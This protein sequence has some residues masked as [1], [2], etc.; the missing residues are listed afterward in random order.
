MENA[1]VPERPLLLLDTGWNVLLSIGLLTAFVSLLQ[2]LPCIVTVLIAIAT[3]FLTTQFWYYR[4][5][6]CYDAIVKR[7]PL[8]FVG[9][10]SAAIPAAHIQRISCTRFVFRVGTGMVF[11]HSAGSRMKRW[12]IEANRF[13]TKCSVFAFAIRNGIT[14]TLPDQRH[15]L[16]MEQIREGVCSIDPATGHWSIPGVN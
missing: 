11:F 8:R 12:G 7:Y 6:L 15:R 3:A 13:E 4:L 10:R 16:L 2:P 1:P 14:V 9:T 5:S